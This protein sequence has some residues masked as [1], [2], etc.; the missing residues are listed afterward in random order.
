MKDYIDLVIQLYKL[1]P[2]YAIFILLAFGLVGWV[3]FYWVTEENKFLKY[4]NTE[5]EKENL[6]LKNK[7]NEFDE[8]LRSYYELKHN[9]SKLKNELSKKTEENSQKQEKI[10]EILEEISQ[11]DNQLSKKV[12]AIEAANE[13]KIN[14]AEMIK[15]AKEK[16][17]RDK[18]IETNWMKN[19]KKQIKKTFSFRQK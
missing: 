19:I 5:L 2:E 13:S 7:N 17:F 18:N 14:R 12:K 16:L 6:E 4:R 15:K 1:K 11:I 9:V 3:F 8:T 10:K